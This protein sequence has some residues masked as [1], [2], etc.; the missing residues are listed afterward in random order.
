MNG[1]Q[2]AIELAMTEAVQKITST[3][4]PAIDLVVSQT[5]TNLAQ[6]KEWA[7]NDE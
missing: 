5:L 1:I 6:A 3:S 2:Q 4:E 7:K